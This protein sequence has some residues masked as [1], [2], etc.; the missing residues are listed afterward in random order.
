MIATVGKLII[1]GA[2]LLSFHGGHHQKLY[3]WPAM[4]IC[5]TAAYPPVCLPSPAHWSTTPPPK[6]LGAPP[7][8]PM[9]PGATCGPVYCRTGKPDF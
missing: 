2:A 5:N 1:L 4:D 6:I 9:L 7:A 3:F 8:P